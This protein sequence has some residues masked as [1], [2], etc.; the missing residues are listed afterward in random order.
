[1]SDFGSY[2]YAFNSGMFTYVGAQ[3]FFM[4]CYDLAKLQAK[5]MWTLY[6]DISYMT[7]KVPDIYNMITKTNPEYL[8]LSCLI[9]RE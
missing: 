5:T 4:I 8:Q 6:K 2:I 7:A 3:N 1:M 9:H